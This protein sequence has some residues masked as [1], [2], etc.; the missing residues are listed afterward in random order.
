MSWVPPENS[1]SIVN[2]WSCIWYCTFQM[3]TDFFA[4]LLVVNVITGQITGVF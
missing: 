4:L 3:K 2:V 1:V